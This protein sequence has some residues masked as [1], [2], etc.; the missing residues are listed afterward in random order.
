M[1]VGPSLPETIHTGRLTLRP[2]RAGD[3]NGFVETQVDAEVRR[4]LGGPRAEAEVR[5]AAKEH[6]LAALGAPGH[7]VVA[8]A[9]DDAMIGLASLVPRPIELPGHVTADGGELELSYVFRRSSWGNGYATEAACGLLAAAARL[10]P[11]Q[12][13]IIITQ[14]ANTASLR[15]A[16]RLGFQPRDKFQQFG[17]EQTLA[18]RNLGADSDFG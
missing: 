8:T 17:A 2:P 16:E 5:A 12:P 6:G 7:Y 14:S 10:L 18:V 1:D 11:E 4:F 13:V 3:V 15:L 9:D